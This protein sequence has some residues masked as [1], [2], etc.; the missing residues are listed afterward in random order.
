MNLSQQ[1]QRLELNL[2]G[3]RLAKLA[4][5]ERWGE[6]GRDGG[7]KVPEGATC[8]CSCSTDSE[9]RL[10]EK[11]SGHPSSH[12][13]VLTLASPGCVDISVPWP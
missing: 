10:S 12:Q 8:P 7:L 13:A 2:N 11:M 3:K 1:C 9:L 6:M 4:N 5:R